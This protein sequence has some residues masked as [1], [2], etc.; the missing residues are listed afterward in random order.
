MKRI[1]WVLLVIAVTLTAGCS[2]KGSGSG[3]SEAESI[4]ASSSQ[5]QTSSEAAETTTETQSTE[6]AEKAAYIMTG[7]ASHVPGAEVDFQEFS[8]SFTKDEEL[9][10]TDETTEETQASQEAMEH[11]VLL[12]AT[13]QEPVVTVSDNDPA[14]A[15]IRQTLDAERVSFEETISTYWNNAKKDNMDYG[16]LSEAYSLTQNYAVERNDSEIL[17]LAVTSSEYSGGTHGSYAESGLTFD[18]K[19]GA[20][21]SLTD[22]TTDADQLKSQCKQEILTQCAALPQDTLLTQNKEDLENTVDQLVSGDQWY[23]TKSGICFVANPYQL[24]AYAVGDIPF[25]VPYRVLTA[26]KT[27]Y[28]YYGNFEQE[29]R[30]GTAVTWDLNGDGKEDTVSYSLDFQDTAD[31]PKVTFTI[32]GKDCTDVLDQN[33]ITIMGSYSQNYYLTDLDVRDHTVEI[34]L[35]DTG[36][37]DDP[38]TYFFRYDGKKLEYLGLVP[39]LLSNSSCQAYGDGTIMADTRLN[40][41]ETA[42]TRALYQI[43]KDASIALRPQAWYPILRYTGIG[44]QQHKHRILQNVMLYTENNLSAQT[45]ELTPADGSV[46]FPDTDNRNWVS[47]QADSGQSGYL[48][49]SDFSTI[50][51]GAQKMDVTDVFGQIVQAD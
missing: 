40:L 34:A 50:G 38:A 23:L 10:Q 7:M 26:L 20:R 16:P 14:T 22:L 46:I 17:S 24:A 36:D 5:A 18:T 15:A 30:D 48:Y 2:A 6:T 9:P 43:G 41:L 27:E 12:T 39:D 21:L 35:P 49:L 42:Y 11:T 1:V 44:A 28:A 3:E 45:I 29:V 25:T 51:S 32:N 8:R 33:N 37:S 4:T 47:V 19:T 31:Q 13:Y